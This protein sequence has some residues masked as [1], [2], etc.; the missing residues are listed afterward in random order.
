MDRTVKNSTLQKS[1]LVTIF[2]LGKNLGKEFLGLEDN[3]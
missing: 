1:E 3:C 2:I